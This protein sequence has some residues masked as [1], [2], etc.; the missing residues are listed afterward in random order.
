M[1]T[2]GG[3]IAEEWEGPEA[4]DEV[5]D[6]DA[7]TKKTSS[8]SSKR[9]S[10][11][12][13]TEVK[14]KEPESDPSSEGSDEYDPEAETGPK[15]R[16]RPNTSDWMTSSNGV[17]QRRTRRQAYNSDDDTPSETSQREKSPKRLRRGSVPPKEPTPAKQA[18][19]A[20]S[21]PSKRKKSTSTQ[22]QP[23]LKRPRSEST[24][25][26]DAVRKYC[27]GKL[28][29][30]FCQIFTRYP[31]LQSQSDGESSGEL[32]PDKKPEDLTA[33]EKESLESRA[34]IGRAHV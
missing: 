5:L 19:P 30:L 23:P 11:R 8:P 21:T 13:R 24:A 33:E 9:K 7:S 32:Q 14:T 31:F 29:E 3:F 25:G 2:G 10:T 1:L 34:K 15:V 22:P 27:L 20:P 12:K 16:A 18:S 28:Q 4:I 17:C 6:D 26:E